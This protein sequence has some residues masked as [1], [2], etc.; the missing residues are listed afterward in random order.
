MSRLNS[1]REVKDKLSASEFI[2]DVEPEFR[3]TKVGVQCAC[4]C[5]WGEANKLDRTPQYIREC[6]VNG[7]FYPGNTFG[8][9][10]TICMSRLN[11][12]E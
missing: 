12:H 6:F 9:E 10:R 5:K 11:S 2:G 4:P 1:D 8:C 3:N 7:N